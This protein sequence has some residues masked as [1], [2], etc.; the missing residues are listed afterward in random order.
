MRRFLSLVTLLFLSQISIA[1]KPAAT[2][3]QKK[4]NL[5][6]IQIKGE[7]QNKGLSVLARQ[8][9]SLDGRITLRTNFKTEIISEIPAYLNGNLN[10]NN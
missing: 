6:D 4:V 9:N 8:K 1:Q 2:G 10:S 3:G 5:D 7:T